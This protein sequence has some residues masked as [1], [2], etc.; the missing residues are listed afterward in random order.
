MASTLVSMPRSKS[1]DGGTSS[2]IRPAI[3]LAGMVSWGGARVR[4]ALDLGPLAALAVAWGSGYPTNQTDESPSWG[5]TGGLRLQVALATS[6]LW[7][8]L[9]VIDWLHAQSLQHE[10]QPTGIVGSSD[11]PALE[12]L[13]SLGWSFAL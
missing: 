8:E 11:L 9:R 2:W 5:V 6:R 4:L 10:I 12:G 7:G 13:A 3:G 1:L